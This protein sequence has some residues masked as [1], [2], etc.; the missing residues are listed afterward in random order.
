MCGS[1]RINVNELKASLFHSICGDRM[2]SRRISAL[3]ADNAL[4]G[5]IQKALNTMCEI[6]L[7]FQCFDSMLRS[8]SQQFRNL[9]F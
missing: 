1:F 7:H 3:R 8:K 2:K 6:H 4:F 5:K 9:L